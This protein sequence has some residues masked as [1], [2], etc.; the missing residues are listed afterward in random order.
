MEQLPIR[1]ALLSAT[2]KTGLAELGRFLS[3]Y[4]VELV[5]TGGTYR[6][7]AEAGLKVTAVSDVTGFPEVLGGRVKTLHPHIHAGILADKDN[8]EHV[9][10]L[11]ELGIA[12][13]DL[14]CV[15]LYDFAGALERG[16]NDQELVEEIDIG[17]PTL[18]RAAAKNYHSLAV[19]PDPSFYTRFQ[20]EMRDR[21]G[22]VGLTLRKELAAYTF[23]M[24]SRYDR[25]IAEGLEGPAEVSG[26]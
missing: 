24:I 20:G 12:P 1:R 23:S 9:S 18:L 21:S 11:R 3:E 6:N 2:D 4:G 8:P 22:G 14:V 17:G 19:L 16:L 15:N 7:L 25:L 26:T 13:F 10:S 5:S